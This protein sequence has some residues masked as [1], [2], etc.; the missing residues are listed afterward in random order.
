V[1]PRGLADQRFGETQVH[2]FHLQVGEEDAGIMFLRNVGIYLQF[3]RGVTPQKDNIS[4]FTNV[5]TSISNKQTRKVIKEYKE[6]VAKKQECPCRI[7]KQN[8]DT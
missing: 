6:E 7:D 4:I 5:I 8:T 2:C 3:T 1:T